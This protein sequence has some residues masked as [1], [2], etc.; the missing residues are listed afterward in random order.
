MCHVEMAEG[1]GLLNE[2]NFRILLLLIPKASNAEMRLE[3]CM[4]VK[5]KAVY[6]SLCYTVSSVCVCTALSAC[7]TSPRLCSYTQ[8]G[9]SACF[10]W[11]PSPG[12]EHSSCTP[13]AYE[14]TDMDEDLLFL[15]VA[16]LGSA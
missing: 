4:Q 16:L 2:E 12:W 15:L 11:L 7:G 14:V 1:C 8:R 10:F 3:K 5:C 13:S 9:A 6:V